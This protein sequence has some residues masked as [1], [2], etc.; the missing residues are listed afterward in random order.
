VLAY[1]L[2]AVEVEGHIARSY[3]RT[4]FPL[5]SH[6][7]SDEFSALRIDRLEL[8]YRASADCARARPAPHT[9]QQPAG[10]G[11]VALRSVMCPQLSTERL[12]VGAAPDTTDDSVCV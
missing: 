11:F 2:D 3:E 6:I 4:E 7:Q 5:P 9:R 1:L 12:A 8:K 10:A